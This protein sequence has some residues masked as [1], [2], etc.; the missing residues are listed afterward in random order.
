MYIIIMAGGSGTRFWP[1]SREDKPKQFLNI[2]GSETLIEQTFS[3]VAS[4]T[5][6]AKTYLVINE[7]HRNLTEHIFAGR[8][9]HILTEP[10]GRNTAPCIGLAAIHLGRHAGDEPMVI[11]PADHFIADEQ[12]FRATLAAAAT[13]ARPGGIVTIGITPTRPETG[14][15]YILK[16]A[17]QENV[18]SHPVY[19]VETFFEKPDQQTAVQY[20][21]SGQYLWNSG[22]FVF[23]PNTILQEIRQQ[24]P[25]IYAGLVELEKHIG[26]S[27]YQTVLADVYAGWRSIS[28]DYG[29]MEH[30]SKPVYV[31][32]GTF[33]WSDVGS[34]EALYDLRRDEIDGEGN[35]NDA[36]ALMLDT[37][38]SFVYS[39]TGRLIA[40][41]GLNDVLVVDTP[42]AVLVADMK[43][44]QDVRRITEALKKRE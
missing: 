15:G 18:L 31:L 40:T 30:T 38:N 41:L 26:Q 34:W 3:R 42:D 44:S 25:D 21:T 37:H 10:V 16:G 13:L 24:L 43:R 7:F 17:Q 19:R 27:S 20:V 9:V 14:Y 5:E 6:E 23:T 39:R 29:V 1:A 11:L 33:G 4:L 22:I 36:A 28:I 32:P 2:V 12:A 35:L 8:R